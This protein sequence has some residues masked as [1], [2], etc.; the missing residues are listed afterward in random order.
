[1]QVKPFFLQVGSAKSMRSLDVGH[2]HVQD[3]MHC[4]AA[5]RLFAR[6]RFLHLRH[7]SLQ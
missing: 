5:A 4:V 6:G 7:L 2:E 3:I 1:M